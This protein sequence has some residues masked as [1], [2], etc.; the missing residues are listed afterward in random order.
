MSVILSLGTLSTISLVVIVIV[1]VTVFA[2]MFV[3]LRSR[4]QRQ[5]HCSRC[6]SPVYI[7]QVRI[8]PYYD[9]NISQRPASPLYDNTLEKIKKTTK[10]TVSSTNTK[11][12]ARTK[13]DQSKN[14]T[15]SNNLKTYEGSSSISRQTRSGEIDYKF[16]RSCSTRKKIHRRVSVSKT[17]Q[18]GIGTI[19]R[20][21]NLFRYA[22][23]YDCR[24]LHSILLL[25][26]YFES[27]QSKE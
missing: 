6:H 23:E 15:A 8:P 12:S 5:H 7:S 2:P 21:G 27:Y 4:T 20:S 24:F 3:I 9:C 16:Q 19:A 10:K 1:S 13:S 22:I 26:K 11:R 18:G 25:Q 17:S 14:G